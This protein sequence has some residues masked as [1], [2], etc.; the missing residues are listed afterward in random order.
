[1][2]P[3]RRGE[4]PDQLRQ[5]R[6][7]RLARARFDVAAGG[8]PVFEDYNMSAVLW[9][10]QHH[11]CAY[12]EEWMRSPSN[13]DTEHFRPKR[14]ALRAPR[15]DPQ[16]GKQVTPRSAGYWWLAWSWENLLLT[17]ATCNDAAHKGSRFWLEDGSPELPA[18]D[19]NVDVERPLLIDPARDDPQGHIEYI[20]VGGRWMPT[21]R[22]GSA[23]GA[24]T[25]T[26]L[27]LDEVP[28]ILDHYRD[29]VLNVL[30]PGI[31]RVEEGLQMVDQARGEQEQ[32]QACY[33]VNQNLWWP[34]VYRHVVQPRAAYRALSWHVLNHHFPQQRRRDYRLSALPPLNVGWAAGPAPQ[35]D[36]RPPRLAALGE[37]AYWAVRAVGPSSSADYQVWMERALVAVCAEAPR[38]L[39]ALCAI[40]ELGEVA[41]RGH[42]GRAV[43]A[44]ALGEDAGRWRV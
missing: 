25:I 36:P 5:T 13:Q 4:E 31:A 7:W 15:Q 24:A 26:I 18:C 28:G 27:G 44:R 30:A 33:T 38:D 23:R 16:T 37:E 39:A 40:F 35:V 32:E 2:I 17:C 9:E 14:H 10:H 21:A 6:W 29:H 11:K 3:I 43:A 34:L 22:G 42:L 1:M 8:A 20:F 41:M 19:F 12:C